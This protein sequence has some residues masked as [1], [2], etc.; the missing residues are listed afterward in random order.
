[1]FYIGVDPGLSGY[2]AVLNN[3]YELILT[4]PFPCVEAKKGRTIDVPAVARLFL[5]MRSQLPVDALC[6][7]AVE[8]VGPAPVGGAKANFH[9]GGAYFAIQVAL[10]A[11]TIPFELVEPKAW[12][13]KYSL[14]KLPKDASRAVAGRLYPKEDFSLKSKHV[15]K[16]EAV[17]IARYLAE[18]DRGKS[19]LI[20]RPT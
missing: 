2:I 14:I 3:R 6:M 12:M 11:A 13:K 19:I 8:R 18:K 15:D 5:E 17:L 10:S 4:A 20:R 9:F 1:M 7:A 16:A